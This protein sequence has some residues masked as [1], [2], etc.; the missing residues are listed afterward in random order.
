MMKLAM[1]VCVLMMFGV[2]GDSLIKFKDVEGISTVTAI[3]KSAGLVSF[4]IKAILN[5]GVL[6]LNIMNKKG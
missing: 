5:K 6:R 1:I 2:Y 3:A 4:E